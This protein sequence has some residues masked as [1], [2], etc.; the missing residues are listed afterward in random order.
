MA[1]NNPH[2]SRGRP[3]GLG[4]SDGGGEKLIAIFLPVDTGLVCLSY[5]RA[6]EEKN[7]MIREN[8]PYN[9]FVERIEGLGLEGEY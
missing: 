9:W 4:V 2:I 3:K 7:V 5:Y 8:N 6:L 1:F